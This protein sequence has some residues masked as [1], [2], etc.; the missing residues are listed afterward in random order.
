MPSSFFV[1]V[2]KKIEKKNNTKTQKPNWNKW[3]FNICVLYPNS[4]LSSSSSLTIIHAHNLYVHVLYT[5]PCLLP[6]PQIS[7]P[8][9]LKFPTSLQD[10]GE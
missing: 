1:H 9:E 6:S 2:E 8:E 7:T 5:W 4:Y 10:P 3:N